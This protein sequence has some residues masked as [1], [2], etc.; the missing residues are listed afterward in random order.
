MLIFG[1]NFA[2]DA[3]SRSW[4]CNLIKICIRTT[5][6]SGP[7]CLSLSQCFRIL[8]G[9]NDEKDHRAPR[10]VWAQHFE[11]DETTNDYRGRWAMVIIPLCKRASFTKLIMFIR[12]PRQTARFQPQTRTTRPDLEM[13]MVI[14]IRMKIR[15]YFLMSSDEYQ[16]DT[17]TLYSNAFCSDPHKQG[18]AR[19]WKVDPGNHR[20]GRGCPFP[21]G[22]S[23]TR[24]KS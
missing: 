22:E 17:F 10:S 3:W 1:W 23:D 18:D 4:G 16:F 15:F 5:Q 24:H 13:L 9:S 12:F 8:N 11:D 20:Q 7:W 2:V 19:D 6:P 21:R 14:L